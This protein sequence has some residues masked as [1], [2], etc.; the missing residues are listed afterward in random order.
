[1]RRRG[2]AGQFSSTF[3]LFLAVIAI[4][5][6]VC[7]CV[8]AS[9][10]RSCL[11]SVSRIRPWSGGKIT[12]AILCKTMFSNEIRYWSDHFV[13]QFYSHN[14][15]DHIGFW[16]DRP[17]DPSGFAG[18]TLYPVDT[19]GDISRHELGAKLRSAID[20]FLHNTTS[21]WLF[22]LVGDTAVNFETVP[23]VLRDLN[24]GTDPLVDRVIQGA[25]L[26][27]FELTYIQGGSGFVFSR[28]AAYDLLQDWKWFQDNA[29]QFRNDDR[30]LSVY[31]ARVNISWYQ[32]TNRFFTGHSFWNFTSAWNAVRFKHHRPCRAIQT[33]KKRCRVYFSRV[34]ELA[35]WHDRTTFTDFIGR[36]DKIRKLAGADLLFWVPNNKPMLCTSKN[37]TLKYYN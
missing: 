37:T 21:G 24:S 26:G 31:L 9:L 16:S 32:A 14:Y 27:K 6:S 15:S 13:P 33:S 25:C 36:I 23:M 5:A 20:R 19:T 35:F 8:Y 29:A 4:F 30:L 10:G 12:I 1:M 17:Q 34:S 7:P 18:V 28:R 11:P 2:R 22:R 3:K